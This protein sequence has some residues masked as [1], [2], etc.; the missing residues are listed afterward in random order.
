DLVNLRVDEDVEVD[1]TIVIKRGTEVTGR[2]TIC[3]A[4]KMIGK[5]GMLDFTIDYTKSVTGKNIRLNT[6]TNGGG[7]KSFTGGVIAAAAIVSPLFL[8][9]KG[10]NVTVEKGRVFSAYVGQDYELILGSPENSTVK[11]NPNST[12]SKPKTK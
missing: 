3:Q 11:N 6:T 8:L 10:K 9:A 12:E 7:E 2:V 5:K 4:S 1:G